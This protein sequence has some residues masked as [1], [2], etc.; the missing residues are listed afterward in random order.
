[1][2]HRCGSAPPSPPLLYLSSVIT[3]LVQFFKVLFNKNYGLLIINHIR[4]VKTTLGRHLGKSLNHDY[5]LGH[6]PPPILLYSP[7]FTRC[8]LVLP[9]L[10]WSDCPNLV[11][12]YYSRTWICSRTLKLCGL[13]LGVRE[14]KIQS[15][16]FGVQ[17]LKKL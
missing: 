4:S 5:R 2:V 17:E 10:V 8:L 14:H 15:L 16:G 12:R 13:G 11:Q 9:L 6:Y 7:N 1:M 3:L